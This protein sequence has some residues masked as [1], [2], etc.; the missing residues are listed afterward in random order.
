MMA[1]VHLSKVPVVLS[2]QSS[3]ARI[4]PSQRNIL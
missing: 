3:F 1:Q 2:L 4:G